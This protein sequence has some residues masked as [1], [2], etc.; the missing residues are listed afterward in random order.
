[1][2]RLTSCVPQYRLPNW[3]VGSVACMCDWPGGISGCQLMLT[4]CYL[5]TRDRRSLRGGCSRTAVRRIHS[6]GQRFEPA[7]LHS[8]RKNHG[9]DCKN[10]IMTLHNNSSKC[11]RSV[12]LSDAELG[13]GKNFEWHL[14]F[15]HQIE[16]EFVF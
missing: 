13:R 1:M 7:S 10:F 16:A 2:T 15:L 14:S 12:S 9:P 4:R 6:N 5:Q 8:R 3:I 11:S